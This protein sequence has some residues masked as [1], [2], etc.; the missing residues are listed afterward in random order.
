[1]PKFYYYLK[2]NPNY[3]N[4]I[5]AKDKNEAMR[6]VLS[7]LAESD[8][9]VKM[10]T[11]AEAGF[12]QPEQ[13]AVEHF[14]QKSI[15]SKE[16]VSETVQKT[17]DNKEANESDGIVNDQKQIVQALPVKFFTEAG[18]D[19]KLENGKLFKKS[20]VNLSDSD[21]YRIVKVKTGA[22]VSKDQFVLERLDWVEI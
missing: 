11:A 8:A 7:E 3:P 9:V 17:C 18:I 21:E 14:E 6:I 2:Y 19:F 1:M 15:P 16:S 10:L 4:P 5:V 12:E 22:V 20:W 13:P